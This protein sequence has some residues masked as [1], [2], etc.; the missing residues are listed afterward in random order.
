[1]RLLLK[2]KGPVSHVE[3][4]DGL[5][6]IVKPLIVLRLVPEPL[7]TV[8]SLLLQLLGIV[9]EDRTLF[10]PAGQPNGFDVPHVRIGPR[11]EL[12]HQ[13][14]ALSRPAHGDHG[15]VLLGRLCLFNRR[16]KEVSIE[17]LGACPL[18]RWVNRLIFC[19]HVLAQR[20][21]IFGLVEVE[22][23]WCC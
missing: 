20:R 12:I 3:L 2:Q 21:I 6:L 7:Q 8:G 11:L 5:L 1:M 10:H 15:I 4:H 18:F 13:L 19:I 9:N 23:L 16:N 22:W 17:R 14:G